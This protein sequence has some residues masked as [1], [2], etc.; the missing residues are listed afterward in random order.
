MQEVNQGT[1]SPRLTYEII[2]HFNHLLLSP[3]HS[4]VWS[5]KKTSVLFQREVNGKFEWFENNDGGNDKKY[6]GEINNGKPNGRG[7]VTSSD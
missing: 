1:L 4:P 6:V 2:S 7:I 5:V 3:D